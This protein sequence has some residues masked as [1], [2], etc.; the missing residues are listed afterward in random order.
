[1]RFRAAQIT[2]AAG[3]AAAFSVSAAQAGMNNLNVNPALASPHIPDIRPRPVTIDANIRLHCYPSR[4]RN[5]RG[6]WVRRTRCN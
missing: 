6:V 2:L 5:D 1:M 4:E 3:L